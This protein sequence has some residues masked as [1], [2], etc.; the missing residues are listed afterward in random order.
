MADGIGRRSAREWLRIV[1]AWKKSGLSAASFAATQG[2]APRTL[3]WWS[4]ELERRKRERERA[5][6]GL[7]PVEVIEPSTSAHEAAIAWEL[8]T[9]AGLALRVYG[10]RGADVL[11]AVVEAM[12]R[13]DGE[14]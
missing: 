1:R 5:H 12:V 3:Q 13:G 7:V 10:G 6:V 2:C 14:R 8:V 9:P 11:H 4:W